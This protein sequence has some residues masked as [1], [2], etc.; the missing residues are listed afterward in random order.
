MND[1]VTKYE[2]IELLENGVI[3]VTFKKLDGTTR[4]MKAT[5]L[6]EYLPGT[7]TNGQMLLQEQD[8]RVRVD[9]PNVINVWDTEVKNWRAIRLDSIERLVVEYGC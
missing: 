3:T 8:V 4:V 6:P 5:L 2:L 9:N 7:L 1:F